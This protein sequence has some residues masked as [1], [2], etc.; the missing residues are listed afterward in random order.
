[1]AFLKVTVVSLNP[2]SE[3]RAFYNAERVVNITTGDELPIEEEGS[4]INTWA[5][6]V[7]EG[8]TYDVYLQNGDDAA[9][10]PTHIAAYRAA[11]FRIEAA[12]TVGQ[13]YFNRLF[14]N[15]N[16]GN[17]TIENLQ[18]AV[19]M[20]NLC[21]AIDTGSMLSAQ[22]VDWPNL[23]LSSWKLP[24]IA[25][26]GTADLWNP[27]ADNLSGVTEPQFGVACTGDEPSGPTENYEF[28]DG[29][30]IIVGRGNHVFRADA[31]E[32]LSYIPLDLS[33][34]PSLP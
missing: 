19:E 28:E 26:S 29:D 34:L 5:E 31:K 32:I 4:T 2:L 24:N 13:K 27:K 20:L 7:E 9:S 1:M 14:E 30:L 25:D 3:G 22:T 17:S 11:V 23:D 16:Q 21:S 15:Y 33:T 8:E 10:Y 6:G 12:N 18:E